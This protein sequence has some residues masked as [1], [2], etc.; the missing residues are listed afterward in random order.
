MR[1]KKKNF[2]RPMNNNIEGEIR[3]LLER[4]GKLTLTTNEATNFK[5]NYIS[6]LENYLSLLGKFKNMQ[7]E[8]QKTEIEDKDLDS[9]LDAWKSLYTDMLDSFSFG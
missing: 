9:K 4:I 1:D 8:I 2:Y 5:K 6:T 3:T 7:K